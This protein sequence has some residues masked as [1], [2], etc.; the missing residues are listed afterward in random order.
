MNCVALNNVVPENLGEN[1]A[2][3]HFE[4]HLQKSMESKIIIYGVPF[5]NS[6][7]G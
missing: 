5:S 2:F 4:D 7:G 1:S 6:H 3:L